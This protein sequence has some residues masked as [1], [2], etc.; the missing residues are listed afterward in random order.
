MLENESIIRCFNTPSDGAKY[1]FIKLVDV[2]TSEVFKYNVVMAWQASN[3]VESMEVTADPIV[4]FRRL[5]QPLNASFGKA[6]TPSPI[7]TEARLVQPSQSR[8]PY[9]DGDEG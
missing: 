2:P 4:T 7:T 6:V 8:L 3:A 1:V 9:C 5:V